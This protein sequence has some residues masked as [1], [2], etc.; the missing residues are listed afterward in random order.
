MVWTS[1]VRVI[2]SHISVGVQCYL[3][4]CCAYVTRTLAYHYFTAHYFSLRKVIVVRV[5][6]VST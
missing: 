1:Q 6:G 2:A 4:F 3:H 5:Y